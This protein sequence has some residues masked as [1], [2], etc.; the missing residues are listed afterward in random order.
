[1]VILLHR[2]RIF[3]RLGS[4][5][6]QGQK[7][8]QVN[9]A[10][11]LASLLSQ[12]RSHGRPFG[13][14][15][16]FQDLITQLNKVKRS[17]EIAE[18]A[19]CRSNEEFAGLSNVLQSAFDIVTGTNSLLLR[20]KRLSVRTISEQSREVRELHALANY[21]RICGY[22]AKLSGQYSEWF[23]SVELNVVKASAPQFWG[24]RKLFIHAEIQL[25]V[26]FEF[27]AA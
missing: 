24:G 21:R 25:L 1:M 3:G 6:T 16:E 4:E 10:E 5:K 8:S 27:N 14:K 9:I 23:E 12:V 11:R 15:R 26:H 22:L 17:I 20:V 13:A 19:A 2:D 18:S 7:K